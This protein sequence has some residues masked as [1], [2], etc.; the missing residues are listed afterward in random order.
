MSQ[1]AREVVAKQNFFYS[2]NVTLSGGG[3]RCWPRV[4]TN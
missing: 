1:I 3:Q 2:L 4:R